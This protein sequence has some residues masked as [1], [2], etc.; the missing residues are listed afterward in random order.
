MRQPS[1]SIRISMSH[2]ALQLW[3]CYAPMNS[4]AEFHETG[5]FNVYAILTSSHK[6]P[7]YSATRPA[8]ESCPML[9]N[10]CMSHL[11]QA[12]ASEGVL[13]VI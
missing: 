12:Q 6:T 3:P 4:A 2:Y 1:M 5:T 10:S 11:Q 8:I 9:C 13:R 7:Q